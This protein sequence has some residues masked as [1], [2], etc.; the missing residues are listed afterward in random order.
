L[1]KNLPNKV[2]WRTHDRGRWGSQIRGGERR[3]RGIP[4]NFTPA[5]K[6]FSIGIVPIQF[7]SL[8]NIITAERIAVSTNI[9]AEKY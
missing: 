9:K 2:V 1:A 4:L 5:G 7:I 3:S 6:D 8:E